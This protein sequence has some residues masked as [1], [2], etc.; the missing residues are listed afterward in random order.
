MQQEIGGLKEYEDETVGLGTLSDDEEVSIPSLD[1]NREILDFPDDDIRD[2]R[3][4]SNTQREDWLLRREP[5]YGVRPR[6]TSR[7]DPPAMNNRPPMD[8]TGGAAVRKPDRTLLLSPGR[9]I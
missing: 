8:A 9:R 1:R 5:V 3:T 4:L 2:E 6:Q 7:E